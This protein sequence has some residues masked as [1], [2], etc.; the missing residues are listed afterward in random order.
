MNYSTKGKILALGYGL[1]FVSPADAWLRLEA[2]NDI[3]LV[4]NLTDNERQAGEILKAAIMS[5]VK[6][7][8]HEQIRRATIELTPKKARDKI[9]ELTV[10]HGK[11]FR[12]I[13]EQAKYHKQNMSYAI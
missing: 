12:A 3:T 11:H 7:A 6:A 1:A 9:E 8:H 10:N 4:H 5:K 13:I 2:L